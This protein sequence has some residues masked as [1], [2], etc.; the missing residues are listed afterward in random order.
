MA[1]LIGGLP[2]YL[3]HCLEERKN[4]QYWTVP[5]ELRS[6]Q[7]GVQPDGASFL[8]LELWWLSVPSFLGWPQVAVGQLIG[9]SFLKNE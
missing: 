3:T 8:R 1:F 6:S 2:V 9:P 7:S 4:R 5:F